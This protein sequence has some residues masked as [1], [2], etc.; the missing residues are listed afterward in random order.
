[1]HSVQQVVT[2]EQAGRII[3]WLISD[4]PEPNGLARALTDTWL[5]SSIGG[6]YRD[7][8]VDTGAAN[9][10]TVT[11][12]CPTDRWMYAMEQTGYG[13]MSV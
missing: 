3:P 13:G 7:V 8:V 9:A 4:D 2:K 1:M 10:K 12:T 11:I 5:R 6:D